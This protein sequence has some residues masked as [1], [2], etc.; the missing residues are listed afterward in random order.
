MDVEI[1]SVVAEAHLDNCLLN[2]AD[3]GRGEVG[4]SL[5]IRSVSVDVGL[6]LRDHDHNIDRIVRSPVE[7][8]AVVRSDR[9][10]C[11]WRRAGRS[12]EFVGAGSR[13]VPDLVPIRPRRGEQ[14]VRLVAL[15]VP[16]KNCRR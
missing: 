11:L 7:D 14:R 3:E 9:C 5:G 4:V 13:A 10:C 12:S 1:F 2:A 15:H 6:G 8:L 16:G